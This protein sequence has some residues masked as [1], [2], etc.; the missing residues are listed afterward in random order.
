MNLPS[1]KYWDE[2]DYGEA[3]ETTSK[4]IQ[5]RPSYRVKSESKA[6]SLLARTA[7]ARRATQF[8]ENVMFAAL[9]LSG[10]MSLVLLIWG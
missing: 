3:L 8:W 4:V 10:V 5:L 9:A 6:G 7:A 1:S 2:T